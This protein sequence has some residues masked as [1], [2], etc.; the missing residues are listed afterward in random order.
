MFLLGKAGDP[1]IISKIILPRLQ[2]SAL[3]LYSGL[4]SN[5]S[6]A[7]Y[8]GDPHLVLGQ[9]NSLTKRA[10]PKSANFTSA[11]SPFLDVNNILA[12]FKSL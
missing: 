1:V 7:M 3:K 10:N 12:S 8:K 5:I 9:E 4:F 2:I 11:V 6:G